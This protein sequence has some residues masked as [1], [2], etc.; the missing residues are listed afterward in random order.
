MSR[1]LLR[2]LKNALEYSQEGYDIKILRFI[3]SVGYLINTVYYK[4]V[5]LCLPK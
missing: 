4:R 3:S 1:Y 2:L 5:T